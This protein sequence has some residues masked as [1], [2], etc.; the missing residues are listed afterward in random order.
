MS[1]FPRTSSYTG[2][3]WGGGEGGT[4][5][6]ATISLAVSATDLLLV[7]RRKMK[8]KV[9]QEIHSYTA[10]LLSVMVPGSTNENSELARQADMALTRH[11]L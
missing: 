9:W 7:V 2:A 8:R 5:S 10:P 11:Y 6:G 4:R 3:I 1:N